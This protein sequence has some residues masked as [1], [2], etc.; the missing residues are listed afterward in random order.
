MRRQMSYKN[1]ISAVCVAIG[2]AFFVFSMVPLA[3]ADYSAG[4]SEFNS[5]QSRN[6]EELWRVCAW[7]EDEI[8]CQ[9]E[10]G[11]QYSRGDRFTKDNVEAYVWYY[12]ALINPSRHGISLLTAY[13]TFEKKAEGRR[14]LLD[15]QKIITTEEWSQAEE[16]LNYILSSRGALGMVRLGEVYDEQRSTDAEISRTV[17][18]QLDSNSLAASSAV[19]TAIRR[20]FQSGGAWYT[21]FIRGQLGSSSGSRSVADT[22]AS[23]SRTVFIRRSNLQAMKYYLL[24]ER[25]NNPAGAW[26]A[27]NIR[28][29]LKNEAALISRAEELADNWR[30]GTGYPGPQYDASDPIV[31]RWYRSNRQ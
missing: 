27:A 4:V 5:G 9:V 20:G 2:C 26:H 24:A 14:A 7:R 19:V 31:R 11:N 13:E 25:Y 30:L 21:R 29:Q 12:L 23:S 18:K 16:R 17:R 10:L 1:T 3:H 22:A 15:L 28:E 8:F 6:A